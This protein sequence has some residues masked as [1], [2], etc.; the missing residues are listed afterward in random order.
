M[1]RVYSTHGGYKEFVQILF[2]EFVGKLTFG[3]MRRVVALSDYAV[4]CGRK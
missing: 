4:D 2:R 3:K 1:A